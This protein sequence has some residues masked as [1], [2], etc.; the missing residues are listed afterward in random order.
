MTPYGYLNSQIL[1]LIFRITMNVTHSNTDW[2]GYIVRKL[3]FHGLIAVGNV[4]FQNVKQL[5]KKSQTKQSIVFPCLTMELHSCKIQ[6]ILKLS[7]MLRA[8]I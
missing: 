3:R 1:P 4:P 6:C 2:C 8:Y 7:K 5:L